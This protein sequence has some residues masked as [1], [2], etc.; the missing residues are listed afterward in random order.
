MSS[1]Q[2]LITCYLY[3]CEELPGIY[4]VGDGD[5][6]K[7]PSAS[8]LSS[9]LW[10]EW[11]TELDRH[12]DNGKEQGIASTHNWGARFSGLPI[13]QVLVASDSPYSGWG[14]I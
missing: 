12:E 11:R 14:S 8:K 6:Q 7:A 13:L 4:Y 5:W 1:K 2:F 9:Q 10:Y 3:I